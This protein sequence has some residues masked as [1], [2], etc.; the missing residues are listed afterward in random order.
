[1]RHRKCDELHP[2]CRECTT[3]GIQCHGY[4]EKPQWMQDDAQLRAELSRIKQ[5]VKDNFR[6]VKRLQNNRQLNGRRRPQSET[7][8][9]TPLASPGAVGTT[10]QDSIIS[11]EA[12]YRES[13]LSAYYLDYLFP[14][15]YPFYTCDPIKGG[16]GWLFWL[17][18]HNPPLRQ[19]ALSVAALHQ[20]ASSE[21]QDRGDV[22]ELLEYHTSA[23]SGLRQA[24]CVTGERYLTD[25]PD[26]FIKLLACG[27]SLISFEVRELSQICI[28]HS[29]NECCSRY[30]KASRTNGKDTLTLWSQSPARLRRRRLLQP[31]YVSRHLS[32][33]MLQRTSDKGGGKHWHSS[34]RR[35]CG[36]SFLRRR[37]PDHNHVCLTRLGSSQAA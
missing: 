32:E 26:D 16:R 31:S 3:R 22:T 2:T 10:T 20:R 15:L 18:S 37:P 28:S 30:A 19:A 33:T 17:L 5:A 13:E 34:W 7:D 1:M 35:S 14:F 21:P 11:Q 24:L 4:G 29:A 23:L 9:N 36:S 27:C 6:R 25:D 8:D 12:S